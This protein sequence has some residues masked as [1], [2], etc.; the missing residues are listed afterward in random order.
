MDIYEMVKKYGETLKPIDKKELTEEIPSGKKNTPPKLTKDNVILDLNNE[1]SISDLEEKYKTNLTALRI[2]LK[3]N[4]I[5]FDHLI[6]QWTHKSNY[7]VITSLFNDYNASQMELKE[8]CQKKSINQDVLYQKFLDYDFLE[9]PSLHKADCEKEFVQSNTLAFKEESDTQSKE[10]S[11][12]SGKKVVEEET[13]KFSSKEIKLLK[14]WCNN[15]QDF[16]SDSK[17]GQTPVVIPTS[18]YL[19]LIHYSS[20]NN[21]D[22]FRVLVRSIEDFLQREDT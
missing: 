22:F 21:E 9:E 11:L 18:L 1:F 2:F 19:K 8:Y 14:S 6:Q 15:L 16:S 13:L 17:D 20:K 5:R 4:G 12:N 3:N 10:T 7:D